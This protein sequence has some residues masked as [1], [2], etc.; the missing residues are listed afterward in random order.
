MFKTEE[1]YSHPIIGYNNTDITTKTAKIMLIPD[2]Q[3][4]KTLF[5]NFRFQSKYRTG[6]KVTKH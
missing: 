3:N 5:M 4:M 2:C 1:K 6:I